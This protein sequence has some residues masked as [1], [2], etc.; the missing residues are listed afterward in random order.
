MNGRKVSEEQHELPQHDEGADSQQEEMS[1]ADAT[2]A[3]RKA[4]PSTSRIDPTDDVAT[5][6][7]ERDEH[8]DRLLR[9]AA[10]FDNYR[11]RVERERRELSEFAAADLIKDLVPLVDDLE[12]ALA[13]APPASP[14]VE[15]YRAGVELIHRQLLELL[16]KRGVR[17]IEAL[18]ADFN[19]H[20]H[21][22]VSQE[23]S[24]GHREG[25]VIEELRR[26]YKLGDR[27]LRP[28][29]VKVASGE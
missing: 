23:A 10:E 5:L 20:L 2:K 24:P 11:K 14:A 29:M 7:R 19:P 27:L 26:G 17:P 13:A 8:L 28:S 16:R 6:K 15:R 25:E 1:P 18:G 21:Q 4:A 9:Q 3:A 12:R 22:A